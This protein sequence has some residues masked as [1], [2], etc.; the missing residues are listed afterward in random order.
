M[1]ERN[2]NKLNIFPNPAKDFLSISLTNNLPS[3][4][5]LMDIS[6]KILHEKTFTNS[7]NIDLSKLKNGIYLISV[8]NNSQITTKRVSI[9]K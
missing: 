5:T 9:V 7:S 3:E 8:I 2:I 1:K 4:L 6:G